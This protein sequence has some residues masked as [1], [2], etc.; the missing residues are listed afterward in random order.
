MAAMAPQPYW[1]GDDCG[2]YKG[3][4]ETQISRVCVYIYVYTLMSKGVHK[5][6]NT[7]AAAY[8]YIYTCV[9]T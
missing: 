1:R 5:Y 4:Q 7:Y 3:L 6:M 9:Y 8:V 2:F